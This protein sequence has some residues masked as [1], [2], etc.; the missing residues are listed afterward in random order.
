MIPAR[1]V[2]LNHRKHVQLV[3]NTEITGCGRRGG[4]LTFYYLREGLKVREAESW[5]LACGRGASTTSGWPG[6]LLCKRCAVNYGLAC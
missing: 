5:R 6:V 4:C 2:V 3:L 1:T